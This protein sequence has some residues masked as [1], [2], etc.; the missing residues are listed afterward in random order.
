MDRAAWKQRMNEF[1]EPGKRIR[2]DINKE[3]VA[4]LAYKLYGLPEVTVTELN[5]YDDKNF[6]LKVKHVDEEADIWCHG[7]VLKVI[8]SLDSTDTLAIDGQTELLLYLEE[9][10]F[11]CPVPVKNLKGEF[12]SKETISDKEHAVRLLKYQPGSLFHEIPVTNQLLQQ[13]GNYIAQLDLA[14]QGF[15]HTGFENRKNIWLLQHC[16]L[17]LKLLFAVPNEN[18][19]SL[20][21]EVIKSFEEIVLRNQEKLEK[22]LIHGDFNEQNILVSKGSENDI[23]D[24]CGILDFGDS[25]VSFYIFELSIAVCYMILQAKE[26]DPF[27]AGRHV[28]SGYTKIKRL[29]ERELELLKICV[30]ARLCQSLVLGAYSYSIEPDSYLLVTAARGWDMLRLLWNT[31]DDKINQ[32]WIS[33]ITA[34]QGL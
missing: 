4:E 30:C 21:T 3:A 24:I 9:Q 13:A 33:E 31:S 17:V 22:G 27:T 1:L 29:P 32:Q 10:G 28:I 23:W 6:H 18:N 20:V 26:L 34:P 16:P 11:V 2:P 8:N 25:H 12:Y 5:G 14:M 15:Q 19:K 7:Y